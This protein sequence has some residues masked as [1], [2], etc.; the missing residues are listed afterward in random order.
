MILFLYIIIL[1]FEVIYYSAFIKF[2]KNEGNIIN[3]LLMFIL[4]TLVGIIVNTNTLQSYLL[5]IIM[6][7]LGMKYLVKVKTSLF[8]IMIIFIMLLIKVLLELPIYFIFYKYLD[9]F[10]MG[11]IYSL[12]KM[13]FILLIKNKLHK[14]YNKLN[15]LWV[16][17]NFYIRY[18]FSTFMCTYTII[19]CIFI[20]FYYI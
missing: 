3:Y 11:I 20:I 10:S 4:I 9:I 6:I 17:N 16:N 2:S 18:L 15:I 1:I 19:S 12:C 8:D 13:L 14:V 5:L 7:T